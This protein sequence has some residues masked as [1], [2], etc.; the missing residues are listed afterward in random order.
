MTERKLIWVDKPTKGENCRYWKP[1]QETYGR[2]TLPANRDEFC[3]KEYVSAR[4]PLPGW[5]YD[6]VKRG[7][8]VG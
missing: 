1:Y 3:S 7:D 4:C 2:C 8:E 5:D 6:D